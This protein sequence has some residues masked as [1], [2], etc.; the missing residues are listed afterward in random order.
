M[1]IFLQLFLSAVTK[2]TEIFF[3]SSFGNPLHSFDGSLEILPDM[4]VTKAPKLCLW[5]PRLLAGL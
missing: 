4:L 1:R 2:P 5:V 3:D